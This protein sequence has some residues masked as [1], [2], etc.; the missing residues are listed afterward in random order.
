[1]QTARLHRF[2]RDAQCTVDH[3][4]P[5]R[6]VSNQATSMYRTSATWRQVCIARQQ[7]GDKFVSHV[8]NQATSVYRTSAP[9]RQVC[10]ATNH[11]R[12]DRKQHL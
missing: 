1:M 7:P 11:P 8:S 6:H 10:I 5:M 12:R 2:G 3:Q 9:R 4:P